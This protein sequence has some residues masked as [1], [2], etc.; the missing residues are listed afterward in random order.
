[1]DMRF[2]AFDKYLISGTI[3][4]VYYTHNIL[5]MVYGR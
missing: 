5:N 4:S 2:F 3:F 1:M